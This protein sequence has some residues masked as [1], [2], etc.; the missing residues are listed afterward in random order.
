M[1]LCHGILKWDFSSPHPWVTLPRTSRCLLRWVPALSVSSPLPWCLSG[2]PLTH[3]VSPTLPVAPASTLSS[4][5]TNHCDR[6]R[7]WLPAP[8]AC[9]Q[10]LSSS[11]QK[12]LSV[13]A[14]HSSP[15]R[16]PTSETSVPAELVWSFLRQPVGFSRLGFC[17]LCQPHHLQSRWNW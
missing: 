6:P 12:D 11:H 5:C 2:W 13:R 9:P 1:E 14:V 10:I 4:T 17:H 16:K 3:R 15:W 7:N 8:V